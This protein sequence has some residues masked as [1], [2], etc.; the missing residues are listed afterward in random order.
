TIDRI[1]DQFPADRQQQIR[2]MLADALKCVISQ[3]LLKRPE[4][5]RIAA[6]E[7]LFITPAISNLMREAKNYQIPSTMQTGRAYGQKLMNDA[8]VELIKGGRVQIKEAYFKC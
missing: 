2:Q 1:V 7:T 5:G 4:G 6:M 8:L 3:V